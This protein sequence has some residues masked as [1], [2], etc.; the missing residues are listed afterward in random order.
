MGIQVI[1]NLGGKCIGYD[2]CHVDHRQMLQTSL[3]TLTDQVLD[4]FPKSLVQNSASAEANSS[5]L[6][7]NSCL[8]EQLHTN[9][10]VSTWTH[11]HG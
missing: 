2:E 8:F 7:C 4:V 1:T 6:M 5:C 11:W 10:K 9:P 3:E